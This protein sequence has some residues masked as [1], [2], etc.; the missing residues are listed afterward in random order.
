MRYPIRS[1]ASLWRQLIHPAVYR[2]KGVAMP[3]TYPT[4]LGGLKMVR[5]PVKVIT[6]PTDSPR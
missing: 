1:L 4:N 3:P 6:P 2:G 5:S